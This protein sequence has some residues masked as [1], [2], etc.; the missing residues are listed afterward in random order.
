MGVRANLMPPGT[1]SATHLLLYQPNPMHGRSL[2]T[3]A[4]QQGVQCSQFI[5]Q[6]LAV[7]QQLESNATAVTAASPLIK[8]LECADQVQQ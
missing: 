7:T 6:G 5:G 4:L 2:I 8:I 3:T 1:R